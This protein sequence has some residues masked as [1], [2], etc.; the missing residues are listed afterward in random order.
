MNKNFQ[1][2]QR[3]EQVIKEKKNASP[4]NSYTAT[5][6][7]K[8]KEKIANKFG[9]EAFETVTAF[10]SQTKN[11]LSEETADLIYHLFVLLESA[12]VDFEKVLQILEER[13]KEDGKRE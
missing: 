5:L 6:F 2:L 8:G 10:L 12:E 11:D 4:S 7:E 1:I 9:E 3:L 13:M